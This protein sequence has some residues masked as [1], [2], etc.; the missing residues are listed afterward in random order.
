[1]PAGTE[2]NVDGEVL[3]VGSARFAAQGGAFCLVTG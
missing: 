2:F 3:E 1:M